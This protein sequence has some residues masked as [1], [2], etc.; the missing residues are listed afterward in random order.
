MIAQPELEARLTPVEIGVEVTADGVHVVAAY[1]LPST[2]R[3]VFYSQFHAAPSPREW[4]GLTE[5]E[6]AIWKEPAIGAVLWAEAVLKEK[7]A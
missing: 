2:V 7:N 5:H 1:V 3:Y 4:Q 6:K